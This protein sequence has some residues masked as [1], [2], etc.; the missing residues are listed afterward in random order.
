MINA[1]AFA[2]DLL[3]VDARPAHHAIDGPVGLSLDD[4]HQGGELIGRE[5]GR[6]SLGANIL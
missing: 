4:G 5:P 2:N 1:E 6:M 3:Q